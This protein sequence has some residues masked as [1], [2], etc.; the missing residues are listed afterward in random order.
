MA[1]TATTLAAACGASDLTLS[2]TSSTGF[3]AG[4]DVKID[5]E[6]MTCVAVPQSGL[7]TVRSRGS[8][9][10]AA[11]AHAIL[12]PAVTTANNADWV[13]VPTGAVNDKPPYVDDIVTLSTDQEI[14][15]PRKN[16]TYIINKASA[17][18]LT[19][20]PGT[21]DAL[22]VVLTFIANTAQAHLL[23][24][25]EGFL[26]DTTSSDVV[27][28]GSKVGATCEVKVGAGGLLSLTLGSGCTLA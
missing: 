18:L 15:L 16:T 11:V 22:P 9:G 19:I 12:A 10:T 20:S 13:A 25:T 6:Y 5:G 24:Y 4:Q 21:E 23:T 8:N 17:C 2:L 1:L 27:T 3:A 28:F 14:T 7:I 26:G